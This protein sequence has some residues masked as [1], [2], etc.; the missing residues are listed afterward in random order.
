VDKEHSHLLLKVIYG[1]VLSGFQLLEAHGGTLEGPESRKTHI[2]QFAREG[3]I[4]VV[5]LQSTLVQ[6]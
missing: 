3:P 5:Q 4:P 1:F 6:S 2:T